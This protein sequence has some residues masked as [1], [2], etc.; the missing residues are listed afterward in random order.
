M[1]SFFFN[2]KDKIASSDDPASTGRIFAAGVASIAI[3]GIFKTIFYSFL[4]YKCPHPYLSKR[5]R[6]DIKTFRNWLIRLLG[7]IALSFFYIVCIM[8]IIK[9]TNDSCGAFGEKWIYSYLVCLFSEL[10]LVDFIKMNLKMLLN[11]FF[12]WIA[13]KKQTTSKC[14]SCLLQLIDHLYFNL[15]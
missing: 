11:K 14:C 6:E 10:V 8:R 5:Q 4:V 7:L 9:L 13:K 12:M 3:M 15:M 1:V 2:S